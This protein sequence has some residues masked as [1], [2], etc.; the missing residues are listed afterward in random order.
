MLYIHA[1]ASYHKTIVPHDYYNDYVRMFMRFVVMLAVSEAVCWRV[2]LSGVDRSIRY[3]HKSEHKCETFCYAL[4]RQTESDTNRY[5]FRGHTISYM[6]CSHVTTKHT[7][8][9]IHSRS[10]RA[11]GASLNLNTIP[12]Q[13]SDHPNKRATATHMHMH[14]G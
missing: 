2:L 4:S 14:C 3:V 7:N 11:R 10:A 9:F 8:H 1:R 5:A 13:P 6:P 12:T